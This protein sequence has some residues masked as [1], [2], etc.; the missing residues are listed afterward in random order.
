MKKIFANG[1]DEKELLKELKK[2]AAKQ[3]KRLKKP[4]VL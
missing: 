4:F 1:S 3:I 2:E